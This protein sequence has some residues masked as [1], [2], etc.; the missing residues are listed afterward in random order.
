MAKR[1]RQKEFLA[2][3]GFCVA[4]V[5]GGCAGRAPEGDTR[6]SRVPPGTAA[7]YARF[8]ANCHG[9]DLGGGMA[10]SLTDGRWAYGGSDADLYASIA[11][12]L[13]EAGMPSFSAGM[14]PAQIEGLVAFVRQAETRRAAEQP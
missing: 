14:R 2:V 13:E 12:G 4:L 11:V 7:L 5:L 10:S 6:A 3:L 1:R 9:A 8:C